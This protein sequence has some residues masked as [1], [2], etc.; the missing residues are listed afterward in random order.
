MNS[1]IRAD[2]LE[3][4]WRQFPNHCIVLTDPGTR[5]F[6]DLGANRA[7]RHGYESLEDIRSYLTLMLFLG[8]YFDKDPQLP[9]AAEALSQRMTM[10]RF[11]DLAVNSLEPVIGEDG[12]YYRRALLWAHA[13]P[14]EKL[15]ANYGDPNG[16]ERWLDDLFDRKY[17]S[18]PEPVRAELAGSIFARANEHGVATIPGILTLAALMFLLGHGIDRDPLYPWFGG[19]LADATLPPDAKAA[20]L[21]REALVQLD[22]FMALDRYVREA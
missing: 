11:F 7:A 9:W 3:F 20:A 22:R 12:E 1:R 13:H 14:F 21:H 2:A 17:R 4:L 8:S 10:G 18:L 15:E 16:L 19:V 5:R 6:I